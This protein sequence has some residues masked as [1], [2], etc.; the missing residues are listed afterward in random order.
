MTKEIKSVSVIGDSIFKGV[1]YDVNRKRYVVSHDSCAYLLPQEVNFKI[2]N[3]SRFGI[4][5]KDAVEVLK[6][7]LDTSDD[8]LIVIEIGGN[9]S[10]FNWDSIAMYPDG[11]HLPKVSLKEFQKYLVKMVKLC[12][13]NKRIPILVTLP[14]ISSEKY[15]EWVSKDEESKQAILKWLGNVERI[16]SFHDEY[17]VVIRKVAKR[18]R[19]SCIEINKSFE[20]EYI[21][22]LTDVD[23]IH[24]SIIGQK[25]IMNVILDTL[26]KSL[27]Y[28]Y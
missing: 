12:L 5:I 24:P 9:D 25:L 2:N 15:L 26:K 3:Y 22:K 16:N 10:D 23:G 27:K 28:T 6:Y 21:D 20:L 19:L 11:E 17:N 1:I 4:T 13:K 18:Y 7:V 14:N 8:E